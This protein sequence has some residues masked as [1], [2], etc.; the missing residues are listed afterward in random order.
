MP[1][2]LASDARIEK[3]VVRSLA[4]SAAV[5]IVQQQHRLPNP[6]QLRKVFA[7]GA[8]LLQLAAQLYGRDGNNAPKQIKI[9]AYRSDFSFRH[10]GLGSRHE[11]RYEMPH[12][13]LSQRPI[14]FAHKF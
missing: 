1:K 13:S 5:G 6:L 3:R 4:R 14:E 7:N 2:N 10:R 8:D 11:T 12:A 9:R